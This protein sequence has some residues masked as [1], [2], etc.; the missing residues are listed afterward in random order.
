[1]HSRLIT[2]AEEIAFFG[3][4]K[5]EQNVLQRAYTALMRQMN[6]MFRV[7]IGMGHLWCCCRVLCCAFVARCFC[8]A[9]CKLFCTMLLRSHVLNAYVCEWPVS[10]YTMLEQFLMKYVWSAAGL[11]IIAIPALQANRR[12]QAQQP[13]TSASSSSPPAAESTTATAVAAAD[14]GS[15]GGSASSRTQEFVTAR[16]LLANAADAIERIMSSWKEVTELAG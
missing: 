16:N 6:Y 10:G 7:R 1:M 3:G 11:L 5:I 9:V 13:S 14:G 8:A 12:A 4:H 15:G 2:H